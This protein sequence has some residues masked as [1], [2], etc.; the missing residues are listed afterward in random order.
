MVVQKQKR[1]RKAKEKETMVNTTVEGGGKKPPAKMNANGSINGSR[2]GALMDDHE[3]V[4]HEV[5]NHDE[6]SNAPIRERHVAEGRENGKEK[7]IKE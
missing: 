2:F 7:K 5:S 6:N 4:M 3:Q 1:N